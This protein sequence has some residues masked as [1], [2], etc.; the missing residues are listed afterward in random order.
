MSVTVAQPGHLFCFGLGYSASR[1]A[2]CLAARGWAVSGTS[3]SDEQAAVGRALDYA[4][5]VF[6]GT[7]GG[8]A[9]WFDGVTHIVVSVPPGRDPGSAGDPVLAH[10]AEALADMPTLSWLGYLSTT[11]VYGNTDGAWVDEAA[12]LNPNVARSVCRAAA[13]AAWQDLAAAH[14]LPLH[15]FRLAGIY[16]PR[17]NTLAQ[18][19]MGQARRIIK[20]GHQF[21]RIHVDDI[22]T[23]LEA[24]MVAPNSGAIYNVCDDEPAAP[25]EV[26]TF[27]CSLLGVDLPDE[28]PFEEAA[29]TMSP[30]GRTFWEDNRRV[31]ND[32]IKDELGVRLAYPT[33]R[34]G[35]RAIYDGEF[36]S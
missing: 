9:V 1:L 11:G 23:V 12:P 21:S 13:E 27:A 3:R 24:S 18:A 34:E 25:A 5:Y 15:I 19:A 20:P 26:T 35:L 14:G 29:E 31:C 2:A 8:E 33:Y 6:D 28:V 36:S 4:M 7:A 17:R 22:A 10:F 32:R 16:G 30:M